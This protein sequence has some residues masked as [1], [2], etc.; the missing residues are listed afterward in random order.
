MLGHLSSG[1]FQQDFLLPDNSLGAGGGG[2]SVRILQVSESRQLQDSPT[3][4]AE[5][6]SMPSECIFL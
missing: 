6:P 4:P 3:P 2:T 5:Y 1:I